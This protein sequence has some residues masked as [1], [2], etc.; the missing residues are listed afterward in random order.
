MQTGKNF[1]YDPE[2][3][4]TLGENDNLMD[5]WIISAN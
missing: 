5:R 1:V 3:K 2:M 4:R